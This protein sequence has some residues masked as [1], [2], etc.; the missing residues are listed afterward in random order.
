M[1]FLNLF[2]STNRLVTNL[3]I[4]FDYVSVLVNLFD[5]D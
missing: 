5:Y 4:L 2:G 1:L 3:C